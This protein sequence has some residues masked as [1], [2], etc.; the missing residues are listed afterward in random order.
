V[1]RADYTGSQ[2][3]ARGLI[4]AEKKTHID[5]NARPEKKTEKT[6]RERRNEKEKRERVKE[7]GDLLDVVTEE[8]QKERKIKG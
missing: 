5:E 8:K 1:V 6:R 4:R 2:G 3:E 7:T